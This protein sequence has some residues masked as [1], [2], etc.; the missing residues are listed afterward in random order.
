MVDYTLLDYYNELFDEYYN[1][2]KE[3][4]NE[5]NL[6]EVNI[7]KKSPPNIAKFPTIILKEVK[8]TNISRGTSTNAQETTDRVSYQIDIYTKDIIVGSTQYP[9]SKVQDMIKYLTF[10]FFL[11]RGFERSNMETWENMNIVYDRLTLIFVGILQSWNKQ[12]R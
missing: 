4:I 2:I 8:N 9:S 12:I 3:N 1:F 11:Y 7:E 10:N 5:D 6:F